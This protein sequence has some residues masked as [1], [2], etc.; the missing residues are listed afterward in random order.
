MPEADAGRKEVCATWT[1][2][3]AGGRQIVGRGLKES[4][5]RCI[6]RHALQI[7]G[8][9]LRENLED[10]AGSRSS[11]AGVD[12]AKRS[13]HGRIGRIDLDEAGGLMAG[14]IDTIVVNVD[15]ANIGGALVCGAYAV[16]VF[17]QLNL[18]VKDAKAILNVGELAAVG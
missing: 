4:W 16:R 13:R 7:Y 18:F 12:I 17:H 11:D 14:R 6:R 3:A 15:P 8:M 5:I 1:T 10:L 2:L 9:P